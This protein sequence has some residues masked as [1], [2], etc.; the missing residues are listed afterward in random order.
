MC[1]DLQNLPWPVLQLQSDV[2]PGILCF[3]VVSGLNADAVANLPVAFR[4][5][6]GN[7]PRSSSDEFFLVSGSHSRFPRQFSKAGGGLRRSSPSLSVGT[8]AADPS[9]VNGAT[10]RPSSSTFPANVTGNLPDYPL[11]VPGST[12]DLS[13]ANCYVNE[14]VTAPVRQ[15]RIRRPSKVQ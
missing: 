12:V 8:I 4:E 7:F 5:N 13:A 3:P 11:I 9:G 10:G 14:H 6:Y 1:P 15:P 2:G